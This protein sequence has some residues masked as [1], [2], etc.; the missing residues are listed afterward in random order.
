MSKK[1]RLE[2]NK[3]LKLMV[4][5][6]YG[7]NYVGLFYLFLLVTSIAFVIRVAIAWIVPPLFLF[8]LAALQ[9]YS[10][11]GFDILGLLL[12]IHYFPKFTAKYRR[13]NEPALF[14][15]NMGFFVFLGVVLSIGLFVSFLN[16]GTR[17]SI[18]L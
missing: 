1:H 15:V 17:F 9:L 13:E 10:G 4:R 11:I 18:F 16:R 12:N 2:K 6:Q 7:K 5:L 3:K 8:Y 14:Y